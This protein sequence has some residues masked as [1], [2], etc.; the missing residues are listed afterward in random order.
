MGGAGRMCWFERSSV[1]MRTLAMSHCKFF[2]SHNWQ[3]SAL[4]LD[5][6]LFFLELE[7]RQ[8]DTANRVLGPHAWHYIPTCTAC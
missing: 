4:G 5:M 6:H 2:A 1:C 8:L 3:T 7:L